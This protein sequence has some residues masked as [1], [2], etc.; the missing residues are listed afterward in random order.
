MSTAPETEFSAKEVALHREGTDA[1]MTI[2]GEGV[3]L[4][5]LFATLPRGEEEKAR[6]SVTG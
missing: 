2:H 1:W 4:V 6:G 3:F 5:P